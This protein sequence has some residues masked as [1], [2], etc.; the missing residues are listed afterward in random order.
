MISI[1]LGGLTHHYIGSTFNYCNTVNSYGT[2]QNNYVATLIG[3][4]NKK[5]GL[6]VGKDSAC[7]DI[8][9][10][11]S[12]FNIDYNL[13]LVAGFYNTNFEN[14][15][16]RGIRPPSVFGQT[17]V[18]GIDYKIDLYKSESLDIKLDTIFSIGII[19]HSI[20]FNF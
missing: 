2:I 7:G 11:I 5:F 3:D 1:L 20:S 19:T 4:S 8:V 10:P 9:G 13:D 18:L 17:P 6:L 14:F 15:S 16:K 12:S